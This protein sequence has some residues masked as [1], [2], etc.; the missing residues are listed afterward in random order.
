MSSYTTLEE[1]QA[2]Q[3]KFVSFCQNLKKNFYANCWH[4]NEYQSKAMRRLYAPSGDAIA[5][6]TKFKN[7]REAMP[8]L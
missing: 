2:E 3:A 6:T 7:M 5:V 1:R 8:H 4:L